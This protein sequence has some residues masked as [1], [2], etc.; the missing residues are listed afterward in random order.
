MAPKAPKPLSWRDF[1]NRQHLTMGSD[2]EWKNVSEQASSLVDQR[3]PSAA[4]GPT[5]S[6]TDALGRFGGR[7]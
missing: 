1:G 3:R 4:N 5:A 2:G 7:E 6:F